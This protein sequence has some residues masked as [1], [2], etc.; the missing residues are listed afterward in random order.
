MKLQRLLFSA[1]FVTL[2]F[3]LFAQS[4]KWV[5]VAAGVW[6]AVVGKPEVYDLL[7]ASGVKPNTAAL[8]RI[9]PS[10]FP[11]PQADIA[12][13]IKDGKTYLRFPLVREEQLYG[14]GL[15]FQTV[16]QRGKILE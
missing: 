7:K 2:S 11:L 5:P 9:A 15:N 10:S 8:A 3:S 1:L 4:V 14:F 13:S 6:K 16:H 12:G